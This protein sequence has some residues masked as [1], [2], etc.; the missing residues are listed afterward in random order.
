MQQFTQ[1][2][3]ENNKLEAGK[4]IITHNYSFFTPVFCIFAPRR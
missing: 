1:M 2:L 3:T 4:H